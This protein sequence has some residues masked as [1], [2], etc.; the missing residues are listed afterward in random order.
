MQP[1]QQVRQA[2]KEQGLFRL[3]QTCKRLHVQAGGKVSVSAPGS[4]L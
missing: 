4:F 1:L 3:Q 2:D